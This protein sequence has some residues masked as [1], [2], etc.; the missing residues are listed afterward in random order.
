MKPNIYLFNPTC[1][2]AVANGSESYM[3]PAMLRKFECELSTLPWTLSQSDDVVLVDQLPDQHFK[4]QLGNAGFNLPHFCTTEQIFSDPE[5][6][7]AAK[8][9][10]FPWG[11]SP[12]THKRLTYLKSNCCP[13]FLNSPVANWRDIHHELYSRK[14]SLSILRL[15]VESNRLN[16]TLS[17]DDIPEICTTHEQIISLQKR[18]E[19]VVVKAP[20]SAS[21][22]GLQ[23]LRHNEYNQ[24]N[25]QVISGYLNQQ[26]F[27]VTGPWH[28]KVLDLSFQFFSYGNGQIEYKGL[29]TFSTDHAGRYTGNYIQ[30]VPTD[31][32]DELKSFLEEN[33]Y[34]VKDELYHQLTSSDYS[35]NYFG[36]LGVDSLIYRSSDGKLKFHPCLEV[37]CRLTMGAVALGLRSHLAE[38]SSGIFRIYHGNEGNFSQLCKERMKNE[39]MKL[40]NGKILEGFLP[41]TPDIKDGSYGAWMEVK[42]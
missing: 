27:V 17:M 10:L 19:K 41:L 6:L 34:E 15:I 29:T 14:Y 11:W 20:W 2:L 31:V 38:R 12:S 5:F 7:S 4:S 42:E 9:Y 30:I 28:K 23:M 22:R 33:I 13:E 40:E 36:W 1:E 18:W 24:T 8:G 37:N 35:T 3:A 16:N 39:P 32:P 21:G 26:G 25:R